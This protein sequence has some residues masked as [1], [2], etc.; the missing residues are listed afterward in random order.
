MTIIFRC[1][2]KNTPKYNQIKGKG[3]IVTRSWVEKC[4]NTKK[5]IPWRRFALDT[6]E[7]TKTESDEEIFA[8]SLQPSNLGNFYYKYATK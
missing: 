5:Y 6:E 7:L 2:F 4:Y 3:K 8:E 1:A